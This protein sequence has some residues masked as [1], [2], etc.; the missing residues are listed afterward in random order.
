ME[1]WASSNKSKLYVQKHNIQ[2]LLKNCIVQL[3]TMENFKRLE[4][5]ESKQLFNQHK[6]GLYWDL[7]KD[8]N[9]PVPKPPPSPP[10]DSTE[11]RWDI[12]DITYILLEMQDITGSRSSMQHLPLLFLAFLECNDKKYESYLKVLKY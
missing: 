11:S 10:P 5:E 1:I 8:E 2:Q 9:S 12:S 7:E 6:S 3:C 4:N